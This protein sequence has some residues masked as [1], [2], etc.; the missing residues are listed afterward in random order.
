MPEIGVTLEILPFAFVRSRD[1]LADIAAKWLATRIVRCTFL[2]AVELS[3]R[4][5]ESAV[6]SADIVWSK[7]R[8]GYENRRGTSK[9][10]LILTK[11]GRLFSLSFF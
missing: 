1:S 9:H 8:W 7:V 4:R 5:V 3:D 10:G 6:E 2:S 11:N